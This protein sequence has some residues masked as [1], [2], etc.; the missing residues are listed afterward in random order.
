MADEKKICP[1]CGGAGY[2]YDEATDTREPCNCK[3]AEYMLKH[4]GAEIARATTIFSSPLF[5]FGANPGDP[6]KLDRTK[7]N[8]HI[9]APWVDLLSH[10]KLCL[11]T[12]GMFF[13]FRIVT[14]EKIK[15]VFV[16]AESYSQRAK[17]KRDDMVT[18]NS[19]ADLVGPEFP[20]VII[21]L[22]FL[23]HK[24]A[25][26]PGALKEALM[27]RDAAQKPTW[28]IEEPSSPF[29]PGNFTYSDD[30]AEYIDRNYKTVSLSRADD[31]RVYE[32]RGFH[33]AV[34]VVGGV[35]DVDAS[36]PLTTGT[37]P[38]RGRPVER[39]TSAIAVDEE[40]AAFEG[41]PKWN[42]GG[43]SSYKKGGGGPL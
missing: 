35:E 43:K 4:L 18:Y 6:P 34:E 30:L 8:L 10:L 14:D 26:A 21:R 11:W 29:G 9:K 32:P 24:N 33:G 20:F 19:L 22:G 5:E 17:S 16:G 37:R 2:L 28:L 15:T 42:K 39:P 13:A 31:R 25:A 3:L 23:G 27:L 12:K 7:E 41:K 1:T 38:V 40:L 36:A